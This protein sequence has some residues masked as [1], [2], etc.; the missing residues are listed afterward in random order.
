VRKKKKPPVPKATPELE[1]FL[2]GADELL[3]ALIEALGPDPLNRADLAI[4]LIHKGRQLTFRRE[5]QRT[6]H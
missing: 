3:E 4:L 6:I 1:K 2:A 5:E